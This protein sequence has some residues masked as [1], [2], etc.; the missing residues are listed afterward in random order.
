MGASRHKESVK[1]CGGG[2]HASERVF[3]SHSGFQCVA[4]ADEPQKAIL[5]RSRQKAVFAQLNA[6]N[7]KDDGRDGAFPRELE[8][9]Q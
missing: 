8:H 1:R 2:K 7:G 9:L 5:E 6:V 3:A 4:K